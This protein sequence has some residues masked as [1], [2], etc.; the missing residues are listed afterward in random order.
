[1]KLW[2]FNYELKLFRAPVLKKA[3]SSGGF[4]LRPNNG[5]GPYTKYFQNFIARKV[6]PTFYEFLREA[7]PIIDAAINRLVSLDGHL[8]IEG[9]NEALV[10][11]IKDWFYNVPVNDLQKGLQT[12][13]QN[14]TGEAFEQGFAI[15]E[16]VTSKKRDDIIGLRV[17]DSKY[18]KFKRNP[19]SGIDIYQ[20][21]DDDVAER[22]LSPENLL[23]FSIHNE[24][25]NPY[26][27]ALL[28]S[29]EFVSQILVTMQNS[30][31][32]VWERFG[33]P[34]YS[35]VYK[36][37]KRDGVDF[38]SRRQLIEDDFNT[39]LRAKREGKSADFVRAIDKDSTIDIAVIGAADKL[40]EFEIPARHVLEQIIAKTGLPPW[41]LG[42]HWSSTER[43]SDNESEILL[44]D[45][46]TRQAAKMPHFYNLV[47]TLLLLRG[48]TWKKGDWKLKWAQVNLKDVLK[49]SQARFMNAQADMYY[50]QN[51]A[52]AGIEIS[53]EDLAIGKMV[54]Q[55]PRV[56]GSKD[57]RGKN[58]PTL[59]IRGREKLYSCRS[60]DP[61]NPRILESF[62]ELARPFPNPKLDKLEDDYLNELIY[63]WKQLKERVALI[64][65]LN[66]IKG[67]RGQGFKD[68]SALGPSNPRPLESSKDDIPPGL[69]AFDFSPE[70][71]AMILQAF[72]DWLASMNVTDADSSVAWYYG[73]AYSLGLIE[74]ATSLGKERPILDLIKSKEIFDKLCAD[75]FKLL[76]DSATDAIM[77]D[78]L[79]AI[80]AHVIAGSNPVQIAAVLDKLFGDQN[81]DWERLARSELTMATEEAKLDEWEAWDVKEVEFIASPDSCPICEAV[82]GV[83]PI[84]Q[85]PMPVRD[86]HPRCR[87]SITF[88]ESET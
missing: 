51:A 29:C 7:I 71:R 58:L 72:K 59:K 26:G 16:F 38:V 53:I 19:A 54:K 22:L 63:E 1:M 34:S 40:L 21:A 42:M 43:M 35:I 9:D 74:A 13:H 85:C 12:F 33:D 73:Q 64:L 70:Q 76:K 18:I 79:P 46:A 39:A 67:S 23:Y 61:S 2:P 83:Y 84:G 48:R 49:Q 14:F 37:S 60:L 24:N 86:T 66:D 81:S 65:K 31:K 4:Q 55:G 47:R 28:R 50:L 44:A 15:G 32:S 11:E 5:Q 56:Q 82:A 57:P 77:K 17:A 27:T 78:I 88:S 10:D 69:E 8:E 20:K 3:A 41:M 36:T 75:G 87:C 68:S 25:Q 52:A 45:V 6:E 80:D 30:L 62:K